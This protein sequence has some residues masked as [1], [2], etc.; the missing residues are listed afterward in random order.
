M[1]VLFLPVA[2]PSH[3]YAMVPLAWAL[4]LAGHEVRIAG[5]P[6]LLEAIGASGLTAVPVSGSEEALPG[7]RE[8]VE[9]L[10]RETGK[11]FTDF[12]TLEAMPP[13]VERRFLQTRQA[14][15]ANT[16]AEVADDLVG[17]ARTWRPDL[18]VSDPVMLAG[19]LVAGAVD[20]PLVHH[21]WG[22]LPSTA[23]HWPGCGLP[24]AEWPAALHALFDRFGVEARASYAVATVDPCPP[25]LGTVPVPDRLGMR[26]IPYNGPGSTPDWLREPAERP[27]V[28]VS[29][30]MSHT[31][32]SGERAYPAAAVAQALSE[33]GAEV[34]ATVKASDRDSFGPVPEGVRVVEELPLH[35]VIPSCAAAVNHGGTGTVL[36]IAACG[37]PQV[38]L[39]L[40]PVHN[41]NADWL[42]AAGAGIRHASRPVEP[43]RIAASVADMLADGSWRRAA[44]A[45]RDEI[46]AQPG[47]ADV[48][49]TLEKLAGNRRSS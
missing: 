36:T 42:A 9:E 37:V 48:V 40:D 8:S 11:N 3:Y 15:L 25:G 23:T 14:A 21:M 33:A 2:L 27:R 32:T 1:R 20:V 30:S 12:G 17:F 31:A 49:R 22:P 5:R 34:V 29:W 19:A 4:R 24:V 38:L 13:E 28:C 39:P 16:T 6:S 44:L 47:P 46:A 7:I 43:E 35:L 10:R 18:V 26:H 45:V 41:V